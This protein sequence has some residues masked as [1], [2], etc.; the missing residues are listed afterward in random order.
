MSELCHKRKSLCRCQNL[1]PRLRRDRVGADSRRYEISARAAGGSVTQRTQRGQAPPLQDRPRPASVPRPSPHN[2]LA[3]RWHRTLR[4]EQHLAHLAL[5]HPRGSQPASGACARP[6]G[7]RPL[8]CRP[9]ARDVKH[10]GDEIYTGRK[11]VRRL[12]ELR[13][14]VDD[15]GPAVAW[16]ARATGRDARLAW[17]IVDSRSSASVDALKHR[18]GHSF[19]LCT[20]LG[21]RLDV[22]GTHD[23][24]IGAGIEERPHDVFLGLLP[25]NRDGDRLGIAAGR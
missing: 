23:H 16:P 3:R 18:F 10:G 17:R 25:V 2:R 8:L 5:L 14:D 11:G 12:D 7:R 20:H 22:G 15:G 4:E 13:I 1:V 19:Q 21:F 6:R 24:T 9:A